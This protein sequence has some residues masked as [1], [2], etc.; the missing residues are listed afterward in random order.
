MLV[1]D[2]CVALRMKARRCPLQELRRLQIFI[3]D[4]VT[5][6]RAEGCAHTALSSMKNSPATNSF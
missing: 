5:K 1:R 6:Q 3:A 2:V 4:L